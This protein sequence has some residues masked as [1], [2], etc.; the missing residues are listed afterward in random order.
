MRERTFARVHDENTL[1]RPDVIRTS[2]PKQL[3][4]SGSKFVHTI[5]AHTAQTLV[6]NVG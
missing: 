3:S 4:V 5:P 2:A 1:D 6:L